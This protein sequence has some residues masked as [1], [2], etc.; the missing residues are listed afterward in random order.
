M[1]HFC[2]FFSSA[3][4]HGYE[5]HVALVQD[6]QHEVTLSRLGE[7]KL[8]KGDWFKNDEM[9]NKSVLMLLHF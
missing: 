6:K 3:A 2:D 8:Q 7:V 9:V 4:D 5:K 1:P